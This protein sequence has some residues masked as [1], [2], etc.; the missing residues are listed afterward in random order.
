MIFDYIVTIF[1]SITN[2]F[3]IYFI[4]TGILLLCGFGLPLPEDVILISGGYLA[5]SGYIDI[6]IF[7]PIAF[8][9]VLLGDCCIFVIGE[10]T[11][12]SLLRHRVVSRLIKPEHIQ[13]AT[14]TIDKYHDKIFFIARFLPGLRATIFFSGGALKTKFWKFFLFDSLAALISIPLIVLGAYYGGEYIDQV[15]RVA[16]GIQIVL[17]LVSITI[18]VYIVFK[19]RRWLEKKALLKNR[20]NENLQYREPT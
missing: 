4:L 5:Y 17:I 15:L 11:G 19:I 3:F 2:P 6:R 8:A 12:Y 20:S 18:I 14:A 16:K 10:K 7:L 9:G 13:K 1:S